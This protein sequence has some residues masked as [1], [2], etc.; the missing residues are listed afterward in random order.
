MTLSEVMRGTPLSGARGENPCSDLDWSS[1]EATSLRRVFIDGVVA[2]S[3][4][5]PV[6]VDHVYLDE[7]S[8]SGHLW[9]DVATAV[10]G[11]LSFLEKALLRKKSI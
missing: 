3:M 10:L 6:V 7:N 11:R 2:L 4:C 9:P 1:T 5:W 8:C